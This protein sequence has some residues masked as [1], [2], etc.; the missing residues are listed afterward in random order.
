MKILFTFQ[1]STGHLHGTYHIEH[2]RG[3]VMETPKFLL[4]DLKFTFLLKDSGAYS[5]FAVFFSVLMFVL[6]LLCCFAHL[7]IENLKC[8]GL[9]HRIYL[10]PSYLSLLCEESSSLVSLAFSLSVFLRLE[11]WLC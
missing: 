10:C 4:P 5:S 8:G 6:L 7:F 9:Y 3:D 1:Q 2:G 11:T